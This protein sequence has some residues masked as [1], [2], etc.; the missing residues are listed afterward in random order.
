MKKLFFDIETLPADEKDYI[1]LKKIYSKKKKKGQKVG[2]FE[3]FTEATGLDGTW[4]RIFCIGYAIDDEPVMCLS[5]DEK[6]MLEKFWEIARDMDLFIGFNNLDFD[7]PFIIQRSVILGVKPSRAISMRRYSSDTVYDIM[8]EW[9]F[10]STRKS[11]SLEALAL[12]L[13]FPSPK[14]N[15]QGSRVHEYYLKGK[16]KEIE[17]YCGA[18]VDTTRKVYKKLVFEG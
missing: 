9:T 16:Y 1:K 5:G 2:T 7:I 18:D 4:G 15:L 14:T 8:Q 10:W 17:K 13:G 6:K 3:E 11:V 12:A